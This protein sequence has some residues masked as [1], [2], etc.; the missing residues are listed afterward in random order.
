MKCTKPNAQATILIPTGNGG[1][2]SFGSFDHITL[3]NLIIDGQV[4]GDTHTA[5]GGATACAA[6]LNGGTASTATNCTFKGAWWNLLFIANGH[7][8]D[9]GVTLTNCYIVSNGAPI[10]I[11]PN[12]IDSTTSV[13]NK[14]TLNHCTVVNTAGGFAIDLDANFAPVSAANMAK[15]VSF[16]NTILSARSAARAFIFEGAL[17]AGLVLDEDHNAWD[18]YWMPLWSPNND[19][20]PLPA[21]A[22]SDI[23]IDSRN[24]PDIFRDFAGGDY[25]LAPGTAGFGNWRPGNTLAGKASDGGSIGADALLVPVELSNFSAE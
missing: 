9:A 24:P 21:L 14:V 25:R 8:G 19:T 23:Q 1:N 13:T 12:Y 3:Q 18:A 6:L 22:A 15:V 11:T 2:N 7:A 4:A 17:S 10:G 16:H 20:V 5:T